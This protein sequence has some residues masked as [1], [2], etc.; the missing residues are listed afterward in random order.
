[1]D[2][3]FIVHSRDRRD[4]PKKFPILRFIPNY[5]F[6]KLTKFSP[7]FVVSKITG[8]RTVE[9][10]NIEG[11]VIGIPMTAHQLLENKPLATKK[12]ID[13]AVL[14]KSRGAKYI[15][16]GAMTSSLSRG[17]RDVIENVPDVYITTGRTLTVKN[18]TDYIF[19][20][21]DLFNLDISNVTIGIVGAAGGIGFGVATLL[22][23]NNFKK[24]LLID[25]E[26]KLIPLK[27]RILD[28]EPD[29]RNSVIKISHQI[30]EVKN[31]NIIVAAT[32]A[33]EVVITSNDVSPGTI[34]INDAQPSDI[35]PDIV[36]FRHDVLVIEGG[37][38]TTP[39]IDCHFNMGLF[40]KNDIFSCLG[41]TLILAHRNE[42]WHYSMDDINLEF[43]NELRKTSNLLD[44]KISGIQNSRGYVTDLFIKNFHE[45]I[46]QRQNNI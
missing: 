24:F 22:A 19:K 3:A 7:P 34:I 41:E 35:S 46:K 30:N 42:S 33:P 36:K 13:A 39:N 18:I 38:L 4:L 32:S 5:L 43:L 14:A 45:I 20:C 31:C 9:N 23:R 15:G 16:L 37:V 8:L 40:K 21:V 6:D 28:L 17:G 25:V 44:Y 26:R 1:M 10:K 12:I 11:I 29:N 27:K 2:F